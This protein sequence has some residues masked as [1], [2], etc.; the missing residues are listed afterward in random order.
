MHDLERA[1]QDKHNDTTP[2]ENGQVSRDAVDGNTAARLLSTRYTAAQ[3]CSQPLAAAYYLRPAH[4]RRRLI[5]M[6]YRYA[7]HLLGVFYPSSKRQHALTR[8]QYVAPFGCALTGRVSYTHWRGQIFPCL[9]LQ[10]TL[11]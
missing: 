9:S 11:V 3:H 4:K 10:L 5:V 6:I 1:R 2:I 7:S 8:R